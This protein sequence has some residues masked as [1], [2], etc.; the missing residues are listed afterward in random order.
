MPGPSEQ[1]AGERRP[2]HGKPT[3]VVQVDRAS[4]AEAAALGR[5]QQEVVEE[6]LQ[7]LSRRPS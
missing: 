3:V 2:R 5:H 6:V 4:D 7:W 1:T